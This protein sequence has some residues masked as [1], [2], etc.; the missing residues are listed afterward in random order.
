MNNFNQIKSEIR[1]LEQCLKMIHTIFVCRIP[2][3]YRKKD[4]L[5]DIN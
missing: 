3:L 4:H 1:Q 5:P 2:E